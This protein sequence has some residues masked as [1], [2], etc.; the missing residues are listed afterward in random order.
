MLMQKKD[1]YGPYRLS[2][3]KT[4]ETGFLAWTPARKG[5]ISTSRPCMVLGSVCVI[6]AF[7]GVGGSFE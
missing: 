5:D 3:L 4:R 2:S 7:V 1:S 6:K